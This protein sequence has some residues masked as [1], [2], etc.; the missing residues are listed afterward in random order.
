MQPWLNPPHKDL[1][2]ELD[3]QVPVSP[4]ET[5]GTSLAWWDGA[6][7]GRA[8]GWVSYRLNVLTCYGKLPPLSG[9]LCRSRSSCPTRFS[10]WTKAWGYGR[11]LRPLGG[12]GAQT[13][14]LSQIPQR[15]GHTHGHRP[16]TGQKSAE[17]STEEGIRA[18]CSRPA[19]GKTR[20]PLR[21]VSDLEPCWPLSLHSPH[22][23][24]EPT[25]CCG[26]GF[27]NVHPCVHQSICPFI[28]R[29]P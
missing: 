25:D 10:Y 12:S 5:G 23:A 8:A 13:P 9:L 14:G 6:G 16:C 2:K 1:E 19:E 7:M 3:L 24:H 17:P 4:S 27:S 18:P 11:G 29:T 22:L 21:T 15:P 28:P 20:D 26:S